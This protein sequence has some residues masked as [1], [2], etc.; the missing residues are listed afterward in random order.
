M[1]VDS[2]TAHM[3]CHWCER[4]AAYAAESGGVR[5]GLCSVHL[6][7]QLDELSGSDRLIDLQEELES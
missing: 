7:A 5:V 3:R 4:R 1:T 2:L 6:Q